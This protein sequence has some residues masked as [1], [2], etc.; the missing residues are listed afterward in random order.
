MAS[1]SG[2][3]SRGHHKFTL[4]VSESYVS[5]AADNYSN[6]SWELVLSP[7]Q[8]GWDWYYSATI[9]VSYKVIVNGSEYTGNIMNYDGRS[10]VT[11][12]SDS[13]RVYHNDDGSKSIDFSFSV[14]DNVSASYLPGSASGNGGLGLTSIDRGMSV[15]Q[16]LN[17]KTPNSITMNWSSGSTADYIW[18]STNNGSSWTAVGWVDSSSGTYTISG[19]SANTTYNIK[20]RARRKDTGRDNNYSGTTGV[21]T[22]KTYSTVSSVTTGSIQPF[23][24]TAYCTSSNASNTSSYEY[25]LCNSNKVALQTYTSTVTY[26]NFSGLSEETTYYIRCRVRSSD[27]GVWSGYVYSS[28]FTTPADQVRAYIKQSGTWK[29]G[30]VYVKING[31]WV[32]AKKVYVKKDGQWII[33]RNN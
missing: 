9:P 3:G 11:V 8:K 33:G 30:K 26:Y 28:A 6:V 13:L 1:C 7:I 5:D 31:S 29:Q 22:Y 27:S 2:D 23:S 20:T 14:W 16:S 24:C 21:T 18:Y 15:W 19:L 12:G 25:A 10:T 4:N 17:G 32:K